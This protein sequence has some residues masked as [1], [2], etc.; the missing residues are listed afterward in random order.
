MSTQSVVFPPQD[1]RCLLLH[2]DLRDGTH[3]RRLR[4]NAL[5]QSLGG[6]CVTFLAK[7]DWN[8]ILFFCCV[9]VTYFFVVFF[10]NL[11]ECQI[12]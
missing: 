5:L 11:C 2:T 4:A 10:F 1:L 8:R 3:G 7:L 6:Q 9:A 12:L